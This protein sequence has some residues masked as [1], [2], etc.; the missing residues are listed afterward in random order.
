LAFPLIQIV[1]GRPMRLAGFAP[2]R[3]RTSRE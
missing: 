3:V 1:T 2:Y